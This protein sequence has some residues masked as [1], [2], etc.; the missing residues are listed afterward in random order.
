MASRR[1]LPRHHGA[2]P[3]RRRRPPAVRTLATALALALALAL[4]TPQDTHVQTAYEQIRTVRATA[5]IH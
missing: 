1:A 3:A 5:G 4:D 2:A